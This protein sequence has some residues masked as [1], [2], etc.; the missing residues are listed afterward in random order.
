[1][2]YGKR[3]F[4][5]GK[6]RLLGRPNAFFPPLFFGQ[7]QGLYDLSGRSAIAH[8]LPQCDCSFHRQ[9]YFDSPITAGLLL[10]PGLRGLGSPD[11]STG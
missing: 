11:G 9:K 8:Q 4:Y 6:K 1:M 7:Q 3:V 2:L 5:L 10:R